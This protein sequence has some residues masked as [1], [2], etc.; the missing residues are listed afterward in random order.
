MYS[1]A[2][3]LAV[4]PLSSW[5]IDALGQAIHHGACLG[6]GPRVRGEAGSERLP[7]AAHVQGTPR[8]SVD[9]GGKDGID[10]PKHKPL[11]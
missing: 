11:A 6:E 1:R 2:W 9:M 5:Q 3:Y 8:Q 4:D 7:C 10:F